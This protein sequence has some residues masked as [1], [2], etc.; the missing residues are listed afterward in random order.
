MAFLSKE[1]VTIEKQV[2]IEV[3]WDD[4][5]IQGPDQLAMETLC[6]TLEFRNLRKRL[7]GGAKRPGKYDRRK[8]VRG[9]C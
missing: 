9:Q 2:P 8:R 6:D 1:L 4:F 5:L 7:F 3:A